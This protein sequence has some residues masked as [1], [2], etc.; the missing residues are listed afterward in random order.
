MAK[1]RKPVP[2]Q[3]D[4]PSNA[5]LQAFFLH[6]FTNLNLAAVALEALGSMGF[7]MTKYRI[8]G[9][10]TWTPGITVGELV[11]TLR[12]T[13]QN[14]NTPMR[15]LLSDGYITA[16]IGTDDR[17]RKQLYPTEKGE[18]LY[19]EVLA[20]QLRR[21]DRAFELAGPQATEGFL[22]VH[23]HLIEAADI[24]WLSRLSEEAP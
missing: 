22:E 17:R 9:I 10:V 13:H 12:V 1:N 4:P 18:R 11:K 15:N 21:I 23:R 7:T 8:L 6:F 19:R 3:V 14:L 20:L 2:A 24:E 16:E 5:A